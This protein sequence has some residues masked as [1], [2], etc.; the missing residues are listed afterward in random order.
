MGRK[1]KRKQDRVRP[2]RVNKYIDRKSNSIKISNN[3]RSG[4]KD[5]ASQDSA[6]KD[7]SQ[8]STVKSTNQDSTYANAYEAKRNSGQHN[9]RPRRGEIWFARLGN[10]YETSVQSGTRPVFI[11]SNDTGNRFSKTFTVLPMTSRM[12]KK[13]LPTHVELIASSCTLTTETELEASMLLAE[14]IVTIDRSALLEKIAFV[15]DEAKLTEIE[16]AVRIHLGV[17]G[18]AG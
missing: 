8:N 9:P 5:S 18:K 3:I 16:R 1:N 6:I 15:S 13:N 7:T 2:I 14:Q 4:D 10:H 11:I 17:A 12:K